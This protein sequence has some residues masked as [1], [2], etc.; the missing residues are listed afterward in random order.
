M[1]DGQTNL[2]TRGTDKER[3]GIALYCNPSGTPGA[4]VLSASGLERMVYG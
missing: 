1:A 3:T 2:K 4:L